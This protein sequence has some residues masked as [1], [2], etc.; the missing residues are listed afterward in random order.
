MRNSFR[1]ERFIQKAAAVLT[2]TVL[3]ASLA[4]PVDAASAVK[5]PA[6]RKKSVAKAP[7]PAVADLTGEWKLIVK[8]E[9]TKPTVF[10]MRQSGT[11][12]ILKA[13]LADKYVLRLDG[14]VKKQGDKVLAELETLPSKIKGRPDLTTKLVL[15]A[16]Q[17]KK[18]T[19]MAGTRTDL[20]GKTPV[21]LQ[22][23]AGQTAVHSVRKPAPAQPAKPAVSAPPVR[24]AAPAATVKP[25]KPVSP[26]I[27]DLA[28]EW[29]L[30]AK[31]APQTVTQFTIRQSG[32][33]LILKTTLP[34][35]VVLRLDGTLTLHGDQ[36]TLEATALPDK[37]KSRPELQTV[38]I[39]SA[40]QSEKIN[41]LQG[42][43]TDSQGVVQVVLERRVKPVVP[44]ETAA[45]AP[46]PL[47]PEK[48]TKPAVA[49]L[50]GEWTLA[51]KS[52][53]KK[54]TVY[55]IRQSGNALIM[56]TTMP[57]KFVLRLDGTLKKQDNRILVEAQTLPEKMKGHENLKL[58]L[59]LSA[60]AVEK[61]DKLDGTSSDATGKNEVALQRV[62]KKAATSDTVKVLPA[63]AKKPA[64][65]AA[66]KRPP[67]V[68]LGID[69]RGRVAAKA[70]PAEKQF[71]AID[72]PVKWGSVQT[73]T[74]RNTVFY[75]DKKYPL[76]RTGVDLSSLK[77]GAFAQNADL[78]LGQVVSNNQ[79]HPDPYWKVYAEGIAVFKT[80]IIE[81]VQVPEGFEGQD[82][83][84]WLGLNCSYVIRCTDG[85]LAK[86]WVKVNGIY[87]EMRFALQ[88]T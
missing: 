33:D 44:T 36:L 11:T 21:V 49:D 71:A 5:K 8:G 20:Y 73:V 63:D 50:T 51:E 14:R 7:A 43:R 24:L 15:S 81:D 13:T 87:T 42:T 39:V 53:P 80:T 57:D 79:A 70:M 75:D 68:E 38:L 54:T 48:A 10:T 65:T 26:A 9:K 61:I 32:N 59:S 16:T 62:T 69:F 47:K 67:R 22:K 35:K 56:K 45:Q 4:V 74:L 1:V 3:I 52:D 72:V 66:K 85:R 64:V 83:S 88:R 17:T 84:V 12:L 27:A 37:I 18:I 25:A 77:E 31:N 58:G 41:L 82:D 60:T 40:L 78:S 28:G 46:K 76:Y 6:V 30:T 23:L 29:T 2:A 55:T 34:D 19:A 86:V